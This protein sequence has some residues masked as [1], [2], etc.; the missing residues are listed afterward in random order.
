MSA[1]DVLE[2]LGAAAVITAGVGVLGKWILGR[3]A[4]Y[5]PERILTWLHSDDVKAAIG[6]DETLREVYWEL[7]RAVTFERAFGIRAEAPVRRLLVQFW[8]EMGGRF[9]M[10]QVGRAA[11]G[12]RWEDGALRPDPTA[13]VSYSPI[14]V[15]LRAWTRRRFPV[16]VSVLSLIPYA[17]FFL[18]VTA[19]SVN[20]FWIV[21]GIVFFVLSI[22]AF[23]F[24]LRHVEVR[25]QLVSWS[26]TYQD[27]PPGVR[28][29][30]PEAD[31]QQ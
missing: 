17:Y 31:P 10:G 13:M 9:T 29:R 26:R 4:R 19:D 20:W 28:S 11:R 7:G 3:S 27:V 6:D 5:A 2:K 22:P 1:S 24:S 23:G 25:D 8:R 16:I 12:L 18:A 30:P 21:G 15:R 14:A